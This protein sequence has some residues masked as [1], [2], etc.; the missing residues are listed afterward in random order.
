MQLEVLSARPTSCC[1][2]SSGGLQRRTEVKLAISVKVLT[3]VG[4]RL[5]QNKP[6]A[7]GLVTYKSHIALWKT[8]GVETVFAALHRTAQRTTASALLSA[9]YT[10]CYCAFAFKS[11]ATLYV[12]SCTVADI[13]TVGAGSALCVWPPLQTLNNAPDLFALHS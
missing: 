3:C 2:S 11:R 4:A 13:G 8:A 10:A 1:K 6:S 7:G 12:I 5:R 9:S